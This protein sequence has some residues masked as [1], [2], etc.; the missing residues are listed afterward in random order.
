[1]DRFPSP[2]PSTITTG[3][4]NRKN[5]PPWVVFKLSIGNNVSF[6]GVLSY[7]RS[8]GTQLS[9]NYKNATSI[10]GRAMDFVPCLI[11]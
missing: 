9:L 2:L 5:L 3:S 10:T 6:S 4:I 11:P 7:L 8:T 1:M